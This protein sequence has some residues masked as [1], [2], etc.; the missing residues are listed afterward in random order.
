MRSWQKMPFWQQ[1]MWTST[2]WTSRYR[3]RC[4]A[5]W[6]IQIE[7]YGFRCQRSCKLSN[8]VYE[9]AGLTRLATTP[10]A[11]KS[12]IS[13]I[14]IHH[15]CGMARDWSLK[16]WWKTLNGKFWD[17]NVLLPRILMFSSDVSIEFKRVQFPMR[18][19][20]AM[21][22]IRKAKRCPFTD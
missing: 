16:N 8:R 22:I 19:A 14:W 5:T 9:L 11:T 3:R 2:I 21:A 10:S 4:Q 6:T 1:Q 13:G 7:R 20:L 17:E 18:L 12:W 15:G